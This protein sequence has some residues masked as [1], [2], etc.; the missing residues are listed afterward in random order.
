MGCR[1]VILLDTHAWVWWV[2]DRKRLSKPALRAIE[3]EKRRAI[4]D[5]S[6][7]EV[8]SLVSKGRLLIDRELREWLEAATAA[9]E[10]EIVPI[11]PSIA[12]RSVQ[13]GREFHGD[14]AD[15]II[16]ATAVVDA[17]P[18]V[19]KDDKIRA[20]PAVTTIW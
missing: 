18:L 8:A 11:R 19:T 4:S 9:A 15:Q 1:R 2:A 14:P 7:R 13:L 12:A 6:L 3:A 20:Y 17:I 5:V 16:V 10:I